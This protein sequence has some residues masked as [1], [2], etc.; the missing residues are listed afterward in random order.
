M[1][2]CRAGIARTFQ[3]VRP[4]AQLTALQNV[5]VGRAYGAAPAGSLARA[6]AEAEELLEFVG[7]GGRATIPAHSLTLVERK[8]LEVA[9]ALATRPRLLLLDEVMAGLN[10]TETSA[11]MELIGR[12]RAFDKFTVL[13]DTHHGDQIIFKHAISTVGPARVAV[14]EETSA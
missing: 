12:I 4:F 11:A 1:A 9:R 6:A 3:L 8:R 13:L 14:E 2:T 5:M 10:P 7:L